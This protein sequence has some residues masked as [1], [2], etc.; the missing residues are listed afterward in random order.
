LLEYV[1]YESYERMRERMVISTN[2]PTAAPQIRRA[3]FDVPQLV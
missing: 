3:S 1:Q 2:P